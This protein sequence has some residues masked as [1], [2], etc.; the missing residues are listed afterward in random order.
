MAA[1]ALTLRWIVLVAAAAIA[2]H[3]VRFAAVP[4]EAQAHGHMRLLVS[5]VVAALLAAGWRWASALRAGGDPAAARPRLLPLWG[6]STALVLATFA[7][8]ELLETLAA[9]E[10][11]GLAGL[12]G[13]GAWT[14]PLLA[15]AFGLGVALL[16]R[17]A[18]EA[19]ARAARRRA[20]RSRPAAAARPGEPERP[21]RAPLARRQAGRGPPARRPAAAH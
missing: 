6:A 15:A 3:T 11:H 13:P 12:V 17:G 7:G 21:R 16:V 19:L 5:G 2:L 9:P 1:S 20:A 14:V 10:G 4:A 18:Q 8:Q